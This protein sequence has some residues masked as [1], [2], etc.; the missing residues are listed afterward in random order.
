M[1]TRKSRTK[2]KRMLSEW[3]RAI[4]DAKERIKRLRYTIRIYRARKRAGDAWPGTA[5]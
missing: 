1:P 5:T 3:D 4:A 2:V